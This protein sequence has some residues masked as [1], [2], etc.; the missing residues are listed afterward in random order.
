MEPEISLPIEY[1]IP[2]FDTVSV[3]TKDITP[4]V[5]SART[6]TLSI[7]APPRISGL[8]SFIFIS[9]QTRH[10]NRTNARNSVYK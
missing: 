6:G 3:Q 7:C 10:N 5:V 9:N 1:F 4:F 2:A 8:E